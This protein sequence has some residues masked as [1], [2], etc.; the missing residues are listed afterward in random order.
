MKT[1]LF[2]V[3][4]LTDHDDPDVVVQTVI[5]SL[6]ESHFLKHGEKI[7]VTNASNTLLFY[8]SFPVIGFRR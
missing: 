6:M 5:D 8:R 3:M 2:M 4:I 7:E 1:T